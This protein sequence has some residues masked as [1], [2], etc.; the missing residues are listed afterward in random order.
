MSPRVRAPADGELPDGF[1]PPADGELPD[2]FE[3]PEGFDPSQGGGPG[4]GQG[5]PTAGEI[6][7][8]DDGSVTVD[9]DGESVMVTVTEDTTVI[10][11][12]E[13]S[14]ADLAEGDDIVAV[15]ET[16]DDVLTATSIR[17]GDAGFGRSGASTVVNR[18]RPRPISR[19]ADVRIDIRSAIRRPWVVMPLVGVIGVGAWLALRSESTSAD[20][21]TPVET[22]VEASRR[23][24]AQTVSAEGTVAPA[25]TD[26]LSFAAAGTVTAVNVE[27][28]DGSGR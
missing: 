1:E 6:T 2:G 9:V 27:A 14:L 23:D 4:G 18:P 25:E 26:D 24:M 21:N 11:T 7:A 3:P 13:R 5:V 22:T 20:T 12:E 8:I 16:T 15:G 10:V 17:L 19:R 28:G